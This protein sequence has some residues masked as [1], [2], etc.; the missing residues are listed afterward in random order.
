[1]RRK[2]G[3]AEHADKARIQVSACLWQDGK[4]LLPVLYEDW[5][6]A[7]LDE[8]IGNTF[9]DALGCGQGCCSNTRAVT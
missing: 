6:R 9:A 4:S 8:S 2:R 1:M 7:A 3:C 5:R